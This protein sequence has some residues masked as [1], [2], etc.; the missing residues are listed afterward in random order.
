MSTPNDYRRLT[1]VV[2][3]RALASAGT[4][5]CEPMLRAT[6]VAP[7]DAVG[8]VLSAIGR[9][10]GHAEL[11]ALDTRSAT[12]ETVLPAARADELRR[13]LAALTHGEGVVET[14]FSGHEPVSGEPPTRE[15]LTPNPLILEEYLLALAR[16][17]P[18]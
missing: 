7:A 6:V 2:L 1:A 13:R 11:P 8:A 16:R 5:V 3:M 15:R 10:G 4:V 18:T 14:D 9:L 17:T 12:L